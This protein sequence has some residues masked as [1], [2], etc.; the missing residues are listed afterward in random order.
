[1]ATD[2]PFSIFP[3]GDSAITI[4]FGN[5]IE[6]QRNRMAIALHDRLQ[7]HRIPGVEDVLVAY[8]SVSVLYDP[9]VVVGGVHDGVGANG[10]IGDEGIGAYAR[11]KALVEN[12]WNAVNGL[13]GPVL[14]EAVVGGP[15]QEEALKVAIHRIPVCYEGEYAPDMAWVCGQTGLSATQVVEIHVATAYRVYMIGFLPGFPYLGKL[16]VRLQ[17]SRKTR[18]MPVVA[19]GRRNCRTANGDLSVE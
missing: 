17:S 4:D 1:V 16:D 19:G 15:V 13:E 2:I 10:R 18:P 12:A 3:L 6:E 14:E 8:S 5:C 7:A 9:Y 11:I